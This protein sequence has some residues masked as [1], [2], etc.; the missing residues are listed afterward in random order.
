MSDAF[1]EWA[2]VCEALGD[3]RQSIILRKGGIAEGREGFAFAHGEFFLFPARRQI[4]VFRR[5]IFP[6]APHSD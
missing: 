4:P 5:E 6:C 3:G 1:K 2:V